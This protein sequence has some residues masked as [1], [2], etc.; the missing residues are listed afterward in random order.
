MGLATV[1]A[2]IRAGVTAECDSVRTVLSTPPIKPPAASTLPVAFI[3]RVT[4][5]VGGGLY[6]TFDEAGQT[7]E[8]RLIVLIE[9]VRLDGYGET[10]ID[11]VA[12]DLLDWLDGTPHNATVTAGDR[13]SVGETEYRAVV[14][15]VRVAD[16]LV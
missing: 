5:A 12:E 7:V 3:D 4:V 14:S 10:A 2:A 9:P 6:D 13:Y 8:A 16:D 1:K 11:A 15:I